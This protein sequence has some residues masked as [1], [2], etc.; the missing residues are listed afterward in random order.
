[1]PYAILHAYR[2]SSY[3]CQIVL[4]KLQYHIPK[5]LQ[6]RLIETYAH[7]YKTSYVDWGDI[8]IIEALNWA[9]ASG[10]VLD[11]FSECKNGDFFELLYVLRRC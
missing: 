7:T 5:S 8:S 6:E 3:N 4:R 2:G 10:W 9:E 11:K 1:M